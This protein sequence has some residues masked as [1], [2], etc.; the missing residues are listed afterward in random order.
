MADYTISAAFQAVNNVS[1]P[2]RAMSSDVNKFAN[3]AQ[4]ATA[5]ASSGFSSLKGVVGGL[6]V[7]FGAAA[8]GQQITNVVKEMTAYDQALA[9][10]QAITGTS[11]T[12]FAGFEKQIEAV[13]K[14]TKKGGTE[15]A[16]AFTVVGSAQPE[17]LKSADALG[18]VTKNAVILGKAG[19]I[20]LEDSARSLTGTMNA[21]NLTAEDSARVMNV[22]A[23][24]E[25]KGAASIGNVS[26][27]MK[28]FGS[29][30]AGAN[31][32]VEE[33]VALVEVM[34][35]KSLFGAEAGTK[36]RGSV[37]KMQK[38][39]VGYASGLFDINDALAETKAQADT[40]GTALERDAFLNKMF[41]AE[42]VSTGLILLDNIGTFNELTDAVT[43]TSA[44][45]DLAA[46]KTNT[47][48][49]KWEELGNKMMNM[50]LFNKE[51]SEGMDSVASGLGWMA[52]NLSTV[53]TWVVRL[54]GAY[55]AF[56]AIQIAVNGSIALYNIALGISVALGKTSI[57][58]MRGNTAAAW[59][60][61][62][63]Q[64]AVA[65]AQWVW[66]GAM[67]AFNVIAAMNPIGLIVLAIVA[68]IAAIALVVTYWDQWGASIAGVGMIIGAFFSPVLLGVALLVS[69]FMAIKNNWESITN[70]FKEDGIIG[71]LKRIGIVLLDT[72]LY[73]MQQ[74]LEMMSNIPLIGDLAGE[75]A[76]KIAEIR[77][78]LDLV[79]PE[80]DKQEA[81]VERS[82]TIEKQQMEILIRDQSNNG[83]EVSSPTG[84]MPKF[85]PTGA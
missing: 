67:S 38:A 80:A 56:K 37:L 61:M 39:G 48:G 70:A 65:V 69:A 36:L 10:A 82:E 28:N 43:G 55:L 5:K 63:A 74:L 30:A 29:V 83:A 3:N 12:E 50:I 62:V 51:A 7:A 54:T 84:F 76:A 45:N 27:S 24:G 44:A 58:A 6:G 53:V 79:N 42:N 47:V 4:R 60:F 49:A 16:N 59:A 78:K 41:G 57:M 15:I 40:Y 8:I 9:D 19:G 17:L 18:E 1:A 25:V 46:T 26:E 33:S 32:T 71:G 31:L 52:D 66:N 14:T 21:F 73:P 23:A 68:L 75:G 85:S 72:V 35:S 11:N 2:F 81:N 22:L 20:G 34:A 77:S 64:K 13:A